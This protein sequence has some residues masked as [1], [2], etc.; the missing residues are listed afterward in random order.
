MLCMFVC[1]LAVVKYSRFLMPGDFSTVPFPKKEEHLN[2][3]P[4]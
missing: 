3:C 1:L 2:E 4:L